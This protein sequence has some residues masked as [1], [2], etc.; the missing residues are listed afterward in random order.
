MI[1]GF[2]ALP[3]GANGQREV[4]DDVLLAVKLLEGSG[5]QMPIQ[6]PFFGC[7][8]GSADGGRIGGAHHGDKV[9]RVC[10]PRNGWWPVRAMPTISSIQALQGLT[11]PR[12]R[13]EQVR[14]VA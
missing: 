10:D 13:T 5:A 6:G 9:A 2:V 14:S 12:A 4:G 3:G 11:P 7:G 1:D 8:N